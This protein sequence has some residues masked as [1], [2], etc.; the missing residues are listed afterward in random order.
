MAR[1]GA[2]LDR[3]ARVGEVV[4][5]AR[6]SAAGGLYQGSYFGE[7]RDPSG[8]RQGRSGYATY[9]RVSSN[10]DIAAYLLWRNFRVHRTLDVGCA[11]GYLVEALRELGVDAHGCDV[12]PFA[13]VHASAGALGYVRL[14]DLSRGLPYGDAEFD[15][16]SCLEILEHLRPEAVPDALAELR[17][18]CG[19]VVYATIPSFGRNPSGP[20]GHLVG[21]VRPERLAH[22]QS[23]GD[24][25]V[26]PVPEEDLAV[27]ADGGPVEGH[28]T[29]AAYDWWTRRF[30][31]AGFDRWADVERRLYA[32]IAPAGLGRFWNLY[33]FAVPDAPEALAAPRQPDCT[34]RQLG[35]RHP[36]IEHALVEA[37][38]AEEG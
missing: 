38:A 4:A 26:G 24:E 10:A 18:V 32:D 21:K 25:F 27:D 30:A 22:Y 12:S 20:D 11:T 6:R 31:D 37:A 17:R 33:V 13:V 7:G 19:G 29:I 36:L 3:A 16:V 28:L 14:G 8:D 2:E 5:E 1:A 35:L 15:L 34:L 23:L 9:D